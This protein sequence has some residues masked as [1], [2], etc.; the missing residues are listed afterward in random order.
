MRKKM[1]LIH[2]R[3]QSL[4]FFFF[5]YFFILDVVVYYIFSLNVCECVFGFK[6]RT[7]NR[8]T[9]SAVPL[10]RWQN[11]IYGDF[12]PIL[13]NITVHKTHSLQQCFSSLVSVLLL[14]LFSVLRYFKEAHHHHRPY[15]GVSSA[16]NTHLYE[17][18]TTQQCNPKTRKT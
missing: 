2:F 17:Y 16:N 3:V 8:H 15:T 7:E 11:M 1:A 18:N 4:F 12:Q 14:L 10:A 5:A 6:K 13:H 9:Q